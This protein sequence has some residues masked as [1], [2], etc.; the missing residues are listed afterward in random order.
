MWPV[1]EFFF[2]IF[3]F[4]AIILVIE[5]FVRDHK[6]DCSYLLFLFEIVSLC[7]H[8]DLLIAMLAYAG[9]DPPTSL[10]LLQ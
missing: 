8:A 7:S 1:S 3:L 6:L 5:T 4:L 10:S 2:K 9:F